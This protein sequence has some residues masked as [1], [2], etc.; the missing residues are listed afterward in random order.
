MFAFPAG[1]YFIYS[2][3]FEPKLLFKVMKI[4]LAINYNEEGIK[5]EFKRNAIRFYISCKLLFILI[6]ST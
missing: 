3:Y 6:Y 4:Q 5:K 1:L 2:L